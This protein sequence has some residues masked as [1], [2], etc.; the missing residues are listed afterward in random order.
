MSG[1]H[2]IRPDWLA[3]RGFRG[4]STATAIDVRARFSANLARVVDAD[5]RSAEAIGTEAF[6]E[7]SRRAA[8]MAVR[9]MLGRERGGLGPELIDVDATVRLCRVLGAEFVDLFAAAD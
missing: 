1:R 2:Q 7:K 5:G 4:V 9:R 8:G 6:P 3:S